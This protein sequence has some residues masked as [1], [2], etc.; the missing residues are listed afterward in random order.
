VRALAEDKRQREKYNVAE[1]ITVL[2]IE[3]QYYVVECVW[4]M[5]SLLAH[6]RSVVVT[7]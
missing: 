5:S 6:A 4:S 2:E 1:I 7:D 3:E